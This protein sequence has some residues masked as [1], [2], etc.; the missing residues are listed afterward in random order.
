MTNMEERIRRLRE[1][2]NFAEIHETLE[3]A[4]MSSPTALPEIREALREGF[5]GRAALMA[6]FT[7]QES[8]PHA[9]A[10]FQSA[11]ADF[12]RWAKDLGTD[13]T[14]HCFRNGVGVTIPASVEENTEE[15]RFAWTN[16]LRFPG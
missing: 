11:A 3:R 6:A 1:L 5:Q 7:D 14:V 13:K 16:V 2:P 4:S 8:D 10:V 15:G 12:A 9:Q